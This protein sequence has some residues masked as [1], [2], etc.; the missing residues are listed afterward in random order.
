MDGTVADRELGRATR[1]R[2]AV[3]T[4]ADD[5]AIRRLLRDHPMAGS[6]RLT[7]E[8][9]PD[10]FR[11]A[12]LAGAADQTIVAFSNG[13]LVCMGRCSQRNCWVNGRITR[14]GYL[15][16]LRLDA[17]M[18]GQFAY[19]RGGYRFFH[20]LQRSS[21]A[22]LYFTSI[23]ADNH[24]ARRFLE[25]G[26][27]GMP[28]YR[29]LGE[30]V[31][32]LVAV[33]RRPHVPRLHLETATR[34]RLPEMLRVLNDSGQRHQ[35]AP[36][37]TRE[38]VHALESHGLPLERFLLARDGGELMA[39]GALWDQ[40]SFRQTV[41]RGYAPTLAAFRPLVN[42][43]A[44]CL[45]TASLP[46]VGSPLAHAFLAP[47]GFSGGAGDVLPDFVAASLPWA[48][49]LGVDFLT[50]ALPANDPRLT[51]LRRRFSIR[52]YQSCLYGVDWPGGKS[53]TVGTEGEIFL[54]DVSLL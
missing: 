10:Y 27:R 28:E 16:E 24:R 49:K 7:F 42:L 20:E 53:L 29:F 5:P 14:V 19:V 17:A 25:K 48:R 23:A 9:E 11:G 32:L 47:L 39:C 51:A 15:A 37:W 35:L 22:E 6:I 33:P 4:P 46:R 26:A 45:G 3:A 12:G 8:R 1:T 38:S 36:V 18:R 30:L 41:I 21:P 54:P 40:R 34:D 52:V 2:F 31:T 50:L 13:R 44:R 43:A